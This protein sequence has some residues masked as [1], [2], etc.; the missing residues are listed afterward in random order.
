[1]A[2][3]RYHNDCILVEDEVVAAMK[4]S[5]MESIFRVSETRSS[6]NASVDADGSA[7]ALSTTNLYDLETIL[8]GNRMTNEAPME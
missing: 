2:S 6:S 4:S 1:M 5:I 8:L 3:F 7:Y